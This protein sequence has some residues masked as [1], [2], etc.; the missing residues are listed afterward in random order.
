MDNMAM[1]AELNHAREKMISVINEKFDRM[2]EC[3]EKGERNLKQRRNK[4]MLKRP[5]KNPARCL[6]L[7]RKCKMRRW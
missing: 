4:S 7:S 3:L 1:I 2:I 6:S 5:P